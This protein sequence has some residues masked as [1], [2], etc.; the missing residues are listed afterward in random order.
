MLRLKNSS[1]DAL[2]RGMKG[3]QGEFA[4]ARHSAVA[5]A[6]LNFTFAKRFCAMVGFRSHS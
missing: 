6:E 2:Y 1:L 5:M 3:K 4:G